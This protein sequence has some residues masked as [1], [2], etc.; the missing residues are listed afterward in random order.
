MKIHFGAFLE[1]FLIEA[2]KWCVPLK[3][4]GGAVFRIDIQLCSEMRHLWESGPRESMEAWKGNVNWA[5][6]AWASS[7]L[8]GLIYYADGRGKCASPRIRWC[9]SLDLGF[10][11]L[12]WNTNVGDRQQNQSLLCQVM[13]PQREC[14]VQNK[15]KGL[16]WWFCLISFTFCFLPFPAH[17]GN[18]NGCLVD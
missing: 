5:P 10:G 9:F 8:N 2:R 12:F 14:L 15:L 13:K 18:G 6:G 4:P 17:A 11:Y 3:E 1:R 16:T 7:L